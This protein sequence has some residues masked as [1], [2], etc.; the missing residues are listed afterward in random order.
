MSF[1][2][3]HIFGMTERD[4]LASQGQPC[5]HDWYTVKTAQP[6][7]VR[8]E[9]NDGK[10]DPPR[11]GENTLEAR[12][13]LRCR[14]VHDEIENYRQHCKAAK[15]N[16]DSRRKLADEIWQRYQQSKQG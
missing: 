15:S 5:E 8:A 13:C 11:I 12:V 3:Y 7:E 16:E 6:W 10:P 4:R 2:D 1:F 9:F 14:A